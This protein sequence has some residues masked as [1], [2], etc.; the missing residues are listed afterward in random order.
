MSTWL[1]PRKLRL[2]AFVCGILLVCLPIAFIVTFL[3]S[4]LWSSLE[5]R[6]GIESM[7][8]SG[9]ADWCFEAVYAILVAAGLLGWAVAARSGRGKDSA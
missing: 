3:L 4:P 2:F 9:P 1:K 6:Y 5:A 7:G 8:H